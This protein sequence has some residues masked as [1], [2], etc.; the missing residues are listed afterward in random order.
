MQTQTDI[1]GSGMRSGR[2]TG[3]QSLEGELLVGLEAPILVD[4]LVVILKKTNI[5][6]NNGIYTWNKDG[7]SAVVPV[8]AA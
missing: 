1:S 4:H 8:V 2:Y 5:H 3:I 7:L 6:T